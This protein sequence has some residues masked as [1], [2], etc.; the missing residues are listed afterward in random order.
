[1]PRQGIVGVLNEALNALGQANTEWPGSVYAP[2]AA[3]QLEI[4]F[5]LDPVGVHENAS[6]KFVPELAIILPRLR[7]AD[8]PRTSNRSSRRSSDP[9]TAAADWPTRIRERLTDA[10]T[11]I[12]TAWNS[13]S[14]LSSPLISTACTQFNSDQSQDLMTADTLSP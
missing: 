8:T 5:Q 6:E 13:L 12:C 9:G 4:L 11:S 1:L 10:T 3:A 14:R 7:D 2:P